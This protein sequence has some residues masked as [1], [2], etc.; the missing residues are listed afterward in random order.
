MIKCTDIC[1]KGRERDSN[2]FPPLCVWIFVLHKLPELWRQHLKENALGNMYLC[3][4][5]WTWKHT[6]KFVFCVSVDPLHEDGIEFDNWRLTV[7]QIWMPRFLVVFTFA[8]YIRVFIKDDSESRKNPGHQGDQYF[9][10]QWIN[11]LLSSWSYIPSIFFLLG[12][13][14]PS[15]CPKRKVIYCWTCYF[16]QLK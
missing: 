7:F 14:Y 6:G 3:M 5:T 10:H 13:C 1:W 4:F 8:K 9:I 15:L 11:L 12:F 2:E 16:H